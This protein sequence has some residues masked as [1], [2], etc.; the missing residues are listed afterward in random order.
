M[1][2]QFDK[3]EELIYLES[4]LSNTSSKFY[5]ELTS[6]M[7]KKHQLPPAPTTAPGSSRPSSASR[8]ARSTRR[9][10]R[11]RSPPV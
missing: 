1:D 3:I 6:Q 7:M 9:S 5:G 8:C 4:H 2:G 11:T 10:P